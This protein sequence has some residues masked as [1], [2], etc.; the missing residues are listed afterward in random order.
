V[1]RVCAPAA[2]SMPV[3][4]KNM[5]CKALV[6][7]ML[8]GPNWVLCQRPEGRL[9]LS[10]QPGMVRSHWFILQHVL[11]CLSVPAACA[12]CR[13]VA[14]CAAMKAPGWRCTC[15]VLLGD[16]GHCC[17]ARSCWYCLAEGQLL[18]W[19]LKGQL[20]VSGERLGRRAGSAV[21]AVVF[22]PVAL[23]CAEQGCSVLLGGGGSLVALLLWEGLWRAGLPGGVC[24][25]VL[26]SD[27]WVVARQ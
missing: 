20:C 15:Q 11:Y 16:A 13:R 21:W 22:S 19:Q 9:L 6:R 17:T 12:G 2:V 8:G 27:G 5:S 24:L 7:T 3:S 18:P 14:C 25:P 23:C 1:H 4:M 10:R 26:W